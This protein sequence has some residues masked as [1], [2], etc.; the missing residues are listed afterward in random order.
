M[1]LLCFLKKEARITLSLDGTC[2]VHAPTDLDVG[3]EARGNYIHVIHDLF[4]QPDL[5]LRDDLANDI[6]WLS[7]KI[8][9]DMPV[10]TNESLQTGNYDV[11]DPEVHLV[12][13][14][15]I[16]NREGVL[17]RE[18][19]IRAPTLAKIKE[20]TRKIRRGEITPI[21]R[22]Q[23]TLERTEISLAQIGSTNSYLRAEVLRLT[24]LLTASEQQA[25]TFATAVSNA[26]DYL[27]GNKEDL[28]AGEPTDVL[29]RKLQG[30]VFAARRDV[31]E[32]AVIKATRWHRFRQFFSD[33]INF[34][35]DL[36]S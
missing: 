14:R 33:L 20:T 2:R 7:A 5:V 18:M 16:V 19:T 1:S 4:Q 35:R 30:T 11:G 6:E 24:G 21:G 9:V 27:S 26:T 29:L 3:S 22:E 25:A 15:K 8:E 36:S 12:I 32:L 13:S 10:Y 17:H 28:V 34:R 23:T 31:R